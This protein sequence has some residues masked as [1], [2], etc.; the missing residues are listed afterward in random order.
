MRA[1]RRDGRTFEAGGDG[2]AL[3]DE[4]GT[5]RITETELSGPDGTRLPRVAGHVAYWFAWNSYLG[6]GSAVYG[7]SD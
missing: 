3:R 4:S 7:V 1:Y 5:W 2:S 6:D